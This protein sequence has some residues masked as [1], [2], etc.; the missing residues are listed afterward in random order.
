MAATHAVPA[1]WATC[2]SSFGCIVPFSL[3]TTEIC[4]ISASISCLPGRRFFIDVLQIVPDDVGLLQ[5]E[6]HVIRQLICQLG[7]L[8]LADLE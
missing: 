2:T 8:Q 1:S 6:A 4:G 3:A 5:E 7:I